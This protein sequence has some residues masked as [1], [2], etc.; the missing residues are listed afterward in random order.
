MPMDYLR[1]IESAEFP[2]T[3]TDIDEIGYVAILKAA[4]LMEAA[5]PLPYRDPRTR[6]GDRR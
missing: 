4:G 3:V 5:V 6:T 2:L 1:R